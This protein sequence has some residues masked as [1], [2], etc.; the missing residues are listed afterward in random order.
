[1]VDISD[2]ERKSYGRVEL[3]KSCYEHT[4]VSYSIEIV[5]TTVFSLKDLA[6]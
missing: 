6:W 4:D 1:L 2:G 5:F 3:R